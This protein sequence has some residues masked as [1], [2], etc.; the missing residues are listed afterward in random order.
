MIQLTQ[1]PAWPQSLSGGENTCIC[2]KTHCIC[3][4]VFKPLVAAP[5]DLPQGLSGTLSSFLSC[6]QI[7]PGFLCQRCT[8]HNSHLQ[9]LGASSGKLGESYRDNGSFWMSFTCS[10]GG[11]LMRDSWGCPESSSHKSVC[12]H[13]L[14]CNGGGTVNLQGSQIQQKAMNFGSFSS[15]SRTDV[16]QI[17]HAFNLQSW[18]FHQN[19]QRA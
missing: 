11:W 18:L 8:A 6:H 7:A 3:H 5:A 12:S 2:Q 14:C 13:R 4:T 10:Q 19:S 9:I 17:S 16:H 15:L 1:C